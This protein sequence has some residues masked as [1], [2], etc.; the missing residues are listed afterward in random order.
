MLSSQKKITCSECNLLHRLV[1]YF[2]FCLIEMTF[3]DISIVSL[4]L[5]IRKLLVRN[6][7]YV[8]SMPYTSSTVCPSIT[9]II[10]ELFFNTYATILLPIITFWPLFFCNF[11]HS[12]T[13]PQLLAIHLFIP[14]NHNDETLPPPL[15]RPLI[16]VAGQRP[17]LT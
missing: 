12:I 13:F 1:L 10:R 11:R 4:I 2:I 3:F 7:K 15:P 9:L 17:G 6:K 8:A 5:Q 14:P 16:V